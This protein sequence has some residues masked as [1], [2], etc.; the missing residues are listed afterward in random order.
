[1]HYSQQTSIAA[2]QSHIRRPTPSSSSL[3]AKHLAPLQTV[4]LL[5]VR[6]RSSWLGRQGVIGETLQ[7]PWKE[8][9][10]GLEDLSRQHTTESDRL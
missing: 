9:T 5:G 7:Q 10:R 3:A 4:A 6:L 8:Q 1:M 2:S